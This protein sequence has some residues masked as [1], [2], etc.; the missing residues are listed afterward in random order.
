MHA[1]HLLEQAAKFSEGC[2]NLGITCPQASLQYFEATGRGLRAAD[3]IEEH[4]VI[5]NVPD[6]AVLMPET[7]TIAAVSVL[8]GRLRRL[9]LKQSLAKL[10]DGG[11][12]RHSIH[13]LRT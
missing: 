12:L 13:F 8:S 7:C 10:A 5:L 1:A 4:Q 3:D 11:N 2:E 9:R 6:D